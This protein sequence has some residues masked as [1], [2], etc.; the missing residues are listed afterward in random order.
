MLIISIIDRWL[1][2]LTTKNV[3]MKNCN[4]EIQTQLQCR[5]IG[6]R[7]VFFGEMLDYIYEANNVIN[8]SERFDPTW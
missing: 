5:G 6:K 7:N 8:G 1:H 2:H 3:P 4:L